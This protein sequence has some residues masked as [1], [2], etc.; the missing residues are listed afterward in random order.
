MQLA[1]LIETMRREGF[2]LSISNTEVLTHTEDGKRKEPLE[3]FVIDV[4]EA[5]MGVV[6]EKMAMRKRE[7]R[8]A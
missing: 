2:E 8:A 4:P 3:L 5:Y 1:I 7:E 6:L